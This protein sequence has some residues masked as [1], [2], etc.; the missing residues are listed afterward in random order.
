MSRKEMIS[1]LFFISKKKFIQLYILF[2]FFILVFAL[3]AIF[4][5][6]FVAYF[7]YD[8]CT[9]DCTVGCNAFLGV[10]Y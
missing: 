1:F 6:L 7:S 4:Y 10:D 3:V 9:I 2:N 8:K 5:M